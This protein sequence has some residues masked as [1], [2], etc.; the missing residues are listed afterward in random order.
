M[1]DLT[2]GSPGELDIC[3][4]YSASHRFKARQT[5]NSSQDNHGVL[6]IFTVTHPHW[7]VHIKLQ[8]GKWKT[9]RTSTT[10]YWAFWGEAKSK[11]TNNDHNFHNNA[12]DY[13]VSYYQ[14]KFAEEGKP[15][16]TKVGAWCDNCPNPYKCNA[17]FWKVTSFG[18]RRPGVTFS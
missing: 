3:F 2:S 8:D 12:I 1:L 9:I 15:P 10:D 16:I 7:D 17:N 13:I 5:D 14:R 6:E 11:D 18:D 4:D